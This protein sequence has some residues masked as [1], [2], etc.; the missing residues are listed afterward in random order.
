MIELKKGE[1]RVYYRWPLSDGLRKALGEVLAQYSYE[2]RGKNFGL[3][4]LGVGVRN[5]AFAGKVTVR[6]VPK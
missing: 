5:L 2:D 1:L 4:Q 6:P 3:H